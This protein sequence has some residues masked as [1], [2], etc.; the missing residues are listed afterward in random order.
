M[1]KPALSDSHFDPICGKRV[2]G[3]VSP[4]TSEYKKRA[5]YFCSER[6]RTAFEGHKERLRLGELA[7]AGAL[8]SSGKVFWGLA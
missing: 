1:G 5:Y 7:R 3:P 8:L 6:C 2:S 4:F